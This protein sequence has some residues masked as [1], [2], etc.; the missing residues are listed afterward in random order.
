MQ[1]PHKEP[2]FLKIW[3]GHFPRFGKLVYQRLGGFFTS[4]LGSQKTSLEIERD[5]GGFKTSQ[6]SW[7]S[8]F[9]TKR[10]PGKSRLLSSPSNKSFS[11]QWPAVE[12]N[13]RIK[14]IGMWRNWETQICSTI[15]GA[16]AIQYFSF[17]SVS[18]EFRIKNNY[19]CILV[20]ELLCISSDTELE[21]IFIQSHLGQN[22][23]SWVENRLA[24]SS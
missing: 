10:G 20:F 15:I 17:A 23:F 3:D 6:T 19:W 5:T 4:W 14:C 13:Y 16:S 12:A 24:K 22:H 9:D 2:V 11:F 1:N 18:S 8:L 21:N 7:R